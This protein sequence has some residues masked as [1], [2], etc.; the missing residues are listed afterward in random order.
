MKPFR[1]FAALALTSIAPAAVAH[2]SPAAYDQRTQVTIEGAVTDFDWSN[3]HVYVSV[4]EDGANGAA[5]RVWEVEAFASTQM[6][7]Y[8][9]TPQ[10][11]AEGDR[12]VVTGNPGRSPARN[13][14]FL[15]SIR[16]SG[17]VLFDTVAARTPPSS[18]TASAFSS[19]SLSGTWATLPGPTIPRFLGE[20]ASLGL[21]ATGTKALQEFRDTVNPGADCVPF[22]APVYMILQGIKS[23]E[24]R[25]D[26]VLLRGE[27]AAVERTVRMNVATHD[28]AAATVQGHSIGR[29]EGD[30]LVVDTAHFADHRMGNA[31]GVPSSAGKHL[32]E[33]FEL[34]PGGGA[35]TYSFTLEDAEYLTQPVTGMSQWAYRPDVPF[36]VTPCNHDN[37]RRFLSE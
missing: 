31:A 5:D 18:P 11:L 8:G 24:I 21:T 6:K 17:T 29:W 9:W 15:Q 36:A 19:G 13:I 33:R 2:H 28:G 22:P 35:L 27:D 25:D 12:V 34:N 30:V 1:P 23:I 3:P 10:T 4:R 37:A 32:V 20:A 7:Q 14:L 26:V 16:K